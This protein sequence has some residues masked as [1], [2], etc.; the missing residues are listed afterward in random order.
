[1]YSD[2]GWLNTVFP[3][4]VTAVTNGGL[5][6]ARFPENA[7]TIHKETAHVFGYSHGVPMS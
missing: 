2:E 5:L 4:I 6:E 7:S 3:V 1:M